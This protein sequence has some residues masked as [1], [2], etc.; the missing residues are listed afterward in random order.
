MGRKRTPGLYQRNGIWQ[1]DKAVQGRRLCESCGTNSL[2]EAGKYLA[3]RLE[4][5]R[6]AAVYGV[7]PKRTFREAATRYLSEN[8]H[9]SSAYDDAYTL[10]LLDSF[11]GHLPL[12]AVHRGSL[13][14]F[15]KARQKD[16]VKSRTINYGLQLVRRILNLSANEWLDEFG[17]SWLAAAPRI[18]LLSELDKREP[19]PLN[20]DEQE[21]LFAELP[22]HLRQMALFA[23]NTGC[24]D[25]EICHLRWEWE[26]P[27]AEKGSVFIIPR[28][29]VKNREERLV[30]LNQ[31]ANS[32]IEEQ[33]EQ[34]PDCVFTYKGKPVT[35]MLNS[36]WKKARLRAGLPEVRVHDLKHTFG[37]CLR[38]AGVGFEDRRTC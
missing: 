31:V 19:Y 11:I 28:G 9:K 20:F 10:K 34:H 24:R 1:I 4:T 27:I 22:Q 18:R 30:V 29:R 8:Q 14:P 7:R 15:I 26:A 12:E 16:E 17:L 38:A 13:Q 21:R 36:A 32:V 3:R 23:A 35:R 33:R 2:E 25:Q 5:L 37:R 6:Q